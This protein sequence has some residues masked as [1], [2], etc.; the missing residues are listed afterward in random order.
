MYTSMSAIWGFYESGNGFPLN[1]I[2][3][4]LNKMFCFWAMLQY[5]A[6]AQEAIQN[7]L[8]EARES[9]SI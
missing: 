5:K 6:R 2:V 4:L 3:F 1:R 9:V 7:Q 8:S